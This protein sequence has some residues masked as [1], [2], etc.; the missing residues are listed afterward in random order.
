MGL[1]GVGLRWWGFDVFHVHTS[2]SVSPYFCI[3]NKKERIQ[4]F[5]A[6]AMPYHVG[7]AILTDYGVNISRFPTYPNEFYKAELR[8]EIVALAK[9]PLAE[10]RLND[11]VERNVAHTTRPSRQGEP[12]S[13]TAMRKQRQS[14]WDEYRRLHGQMVLSVRTETETF[15]RPE[16]ILDIHKELALLNKAIKEWETDKILPPI[17]SLPIL[18]EEEIAADRKRLAQ[19]RQK[20]FKVKNDA[21]QADLLAELLVERNKL[22]QKLN[23]EK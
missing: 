20:I 2:P 11:K 1:V 18:N 5:F 16:R 14:L 12:A 13:V 10:I 17:T 23:I 6:D 8:S 4:K 15:D 21:T 22:Y 7:L 19:V 9:N 3:V